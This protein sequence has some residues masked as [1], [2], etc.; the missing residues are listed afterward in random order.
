MLTKL[1]L[2]GDER[3]CHDYLK[4]IPPGRYRDQYMLIDVFKSLPCGKY[5]LVHW[6]RKWWFCKCKH[7][8]IIK[9]VSSAIAKEIYRKVEYT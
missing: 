5:K 1:I 9:D 4:A 2:S 8:T 7:V 6:S 3:D